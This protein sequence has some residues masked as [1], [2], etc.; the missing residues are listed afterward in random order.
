MILNT[1]W[2]NRYVKELNAY[3]DCIS[4][5]RE[6]P[7]L[8][9]KVFSEDPIYEVFSAEE[10]KP[11][12]IKKAILRPLITDFI[13]KKEQEL[14]ESDTP[15]NEPSNPDFKQSTSTVPKSLEQQALELEARFSNCSK[16]FIEEDNNDKYVCFSYEPLKDLVSDYEFVDNYKDYFQD[17]IPGS[18][19]DPREDII[20]YAKLF[21]PSI[22]AYAQKS[23]YLSA[24]IINVES[25]PQII[26]AGIIPDS[27][28][29][30]K[31]HVNLGRFVGLGIDANLT[32]PVREHVSLNFLK[33]FAISYQGSSI[34]PIYEGADDFKDPI[35]T[36]DSSF[37]SAQLVLPFSVKQSELLKKIIKS[38]GYSKYNK[39]F[40]Q[41]MYFLKNSKRL[42]DSFLTEKIS[43]NGKVKKVF[44]RKYVDLETGQIYTM[45]KDGKYHKVEPSKEKENVNDKEL[46]N[47]DR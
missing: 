19:N 37:V 3:S 41:H 29:D 4:A 1:F 8:H 28:S 39:N 12:I 33:D 42:P 35:N 46:D 20:F 40:I 45:D 21:N 14:L 15:S 7:E 18:K 44:E 9:S 43:P 27:Y 36:Y 10:L 38:N 13:L 6:N 16:P 47:Y 31:S 32:Y 23:D 22:A 30:D 26:N 11:I 2:L 17:L 34:L 25:N 24:L 5:I